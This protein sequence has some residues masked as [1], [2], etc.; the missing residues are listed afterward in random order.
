MNIMDLGLKF[1]PVDSI[2]PFSIKTLRAKHR[3]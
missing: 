2:K 1:P 3:K